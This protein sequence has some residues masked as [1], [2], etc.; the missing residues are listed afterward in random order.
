MNNMESSTVRRVSLVGVF[1]SCLLVSACATQHV[2]TAP[3]LV[4]GLGSGATSS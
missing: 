2:A 4:K 1:A 3:A